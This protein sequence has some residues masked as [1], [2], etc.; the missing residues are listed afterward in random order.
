MPRRY[1]SIR[2]VVFECERRTEEKRKRGDFVS[3]VENES[4]RGL[5]A[6]VVCNRGKRSEG[7]REGE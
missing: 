3:M 6:L 5:R 4:K 1:V 7:G 2:L